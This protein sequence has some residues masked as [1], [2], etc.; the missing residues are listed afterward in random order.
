MD[1]D[2][3]KKNSGVLESRV[4]K[5]RSKLGGFTKDSRKL[6]EFALNDVDIF[7]LVNIKSRENED[8][9]KGKAKGKDNS[10]PNAFNKAKRKIFEDLKEADIFTK[11][12]FEQELIQRH[13]REI[14]NPNDIPNIDF[15][16]SS[17]YA[18]MKS[19]DFIKKK[20]KGVVTYK[21]N[22]IGGREYTFSFLIFDENKFSK[23]KSFDVHAYKVVMWLYIAGKYGGKTC[24]EKLNISLY[25]A[26]VKKVLPASKM[27]ILSSENCNT[28]VTTSCTKNGVIFL[29]RE[30][31]WFKVLI[32]ESFHIFGLDFS[33][34]FS[35]VLNAK[36]TKVFPI[37]SQWNIFESYTE[38]W[39]ELLNV[40]FASYFIACISD[41]NTRK[42]TG[43]PLQK[44]NFDTFS[45]YVDFLFEIEQSFTVFQVNKILNF[46]D[47]KLMDLHRKNKNAMASRKYLYR[48]NTNVFSYYIL[49]MIL[50]LNRD[51]TLQ[52]FSTHNDNLL[53]FSSK[54]ADVEQY[55]DYL[56]KK[57]EDP[58]L[59]RVMLA[60]QQ[61]YIR[62][63]NKNTKWSN[64]INT[65]AR[66][67]VVELL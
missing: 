16:S 52:W 25:F 43:N 38:F 67:S 13:V 42:S 45:N 36:M 6:V 22:D 65:T 28:A 55:G 35:H 15:V 31:E 34:Q 54:R 10:S 30:E 19:I 61:K 3:K 39:A 40:M 7:N 4:A 5:T 1:K 53:K 66:M 37:Q 12:Q 17:T 29:Y 56:I 44:A 59:H 47:L 20:A 51:E 63:L 64:Y 14:K 2:L 57:F 27:D 11:Q 24:A 49:K 23:L 18:S 21:F 48:E 58:A 33:Y 8:K 46:M 26:D 50:F 60:M 9:D 32:H 62:I 41:K